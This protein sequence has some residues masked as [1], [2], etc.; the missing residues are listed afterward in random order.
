MGY[1][2]AMAVYDDVKRAF[3][4]ILAPQL[5]E[6]RGEMNSRFAQ[7]E[8]RITELRAEM[9]TRFAAA[10]SQTGQ[11]RAELR[12]EISNV[13]TDLVRIEQVFQDHAG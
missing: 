1:H 13:H 5:A 6:I 8:A 3:Q 9:N 2:S 7:V 11:L 4:D 10:E 12:Q